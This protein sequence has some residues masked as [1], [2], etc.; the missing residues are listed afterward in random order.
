[1]PYSQRLI[2][3]VGKKDKCERIPPRRWNRV[4]NRVDKC[5]ISC[6]ASYMN[7]LFIS[8]KKR[9][10]NQ[11]FTL[12]ELLVIIAIIGILA[13]FAVANFTGAQARAR[14]AQ[15][16]N[17]LKQI[18]DALQFYYNDNTAFPLT[19]N[20]WHKISDLAPFLEPNYIKKIPPD[21]KGGYDYIWPNICP[22]HCG[23]SYYA[24]PNQCG[25]Y[26]SGYYMLNTGL[27]NKSDPATI[28]NRVVAGNPVILCNGENP[29][30][31]PN[32]GDH[33]QY[34]VTTP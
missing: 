2:G 25:N 28:G 9:F 30:T 21:P 22:P 17:D 29:G 13:T 12:I 31:D 16:K 18:Q 20:T 15:R 34:V 14:D 26:S 8:S 32:W 3:A 1:M 23:Y 24:W 7:L 4:W 5:D 19:D 33:S 6:H 10:N 27:E 11:G